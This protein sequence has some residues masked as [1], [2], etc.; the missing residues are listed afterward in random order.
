V[1]DAGLKEL[2]EMKSLRYLYL[3]SRGVTDTGVDE[4]KKALPDCKVSNAFS[5]RRGR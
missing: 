4:L 1:T 3:G 2:T 5:K